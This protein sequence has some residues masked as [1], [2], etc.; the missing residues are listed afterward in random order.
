[1]VLYRA[2]S[3]SWRELWSSTEHGLGPGPGPGESYGP[4]QSMVPR[5][6]HTYVYVRCPDVLTHGQGRAGQGPRNVPRSHAI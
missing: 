2:W 4:L 1:M 5:H 3:W 6:I